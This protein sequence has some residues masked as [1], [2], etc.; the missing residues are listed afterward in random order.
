MP[1]NASNR[2]NRAGAAVR[3]IWGDGAKQRRQREKQMFHQLLTPVGD[4]LALSFLVA[5]IPIF[6]VL[7]ML[8][9][10]KRPAWQSSFA[11]Q[12]PTGDRAGC[13]AVPLNLALSHG[14]R[15]CPRCGRSCSCSPPS[16][17][18]TSRYSRAFDAFRRWVLAHLPNDKRIVLIVIGYGFGS[19]LEGVSGFGAPVAITASLLIMLG[20]KSLDAV[21][22]ALIFNT[23][24]VAFGS[25]GIPITTLAGVTSLPAPTLG[26][27]VGRQLPF[28]AMLLPFYVMAMYGGL[29][30]VRALFPVLLVAGGA[31]GGAVHLLQL[32]ELCADRRA[33]GAERAT[34]HRAVPQSV[35]TQ[36]RPGICAG[37]R[38]LQRNPYR[39]CHRPHLAGLAALAD[40]VRR[41]HGL[42]ALQG[43]HLGSAADPVAG[44]AQ[45][46]LHHPV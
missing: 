21:V 9:I 43:R 37:R 30:S 10:L 32:C 19:L 12:P 20:F 4:S 27:M 15:R 26:A 45:P 42:D 39:P 18:T 25:L 3:K 8:G 35:A 29:K 41:G 22:Y 6:V 31:F 34:V 23:A 7:L 13:L 14:G 2:G 17:F 1:A 5:A 36:A 11:G 16:R 33:V 28:F 40:H 24:P 46:G 38:P 44:P